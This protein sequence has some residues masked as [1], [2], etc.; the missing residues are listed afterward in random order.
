MINKKLVLLIVVWVLLLFAAAKVSSFFIVNRTSYELP[1]NLQA[2][3]RSFVLPWLNFD[4]RNFLD[5]ASKGYFQKGEH[6]LRAFF[7]LYPLL[8]YLVSKV[9]IGLVHSGLL[10]SYLAAFS[11]FYILYKL[12]EADDGKKIALKTVIL[13]LTFPT[14]FFFLAYY[15]ESLYLLCSLLV[16]WFLKKKNFGKA[17]LF[18]IFASATRVIGAVLSLAVLYEAYLYFRKKKRFP[19]ISFLSPLGLVGYSIYSFFA[20]GDPFT[21]LHGWSSWGKTFSVLGPFKSLANGLYNVARGPQPFFDSPFV[22]PVSILELVSL[23]FL[24][25]II[26]W[27]YRKIKPIYWYY[28]VINSYI[29]LAG[30][31]LQSLPRYILVL[32]PMYI[33]LAKKIKG[34]MFVIYNVVSFIILMVLCA[35]FLRGYWIS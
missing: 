30:G 13:S 11:S 12:V 6:N 20:V 23:I 16:F 26:F 18:A 19:L 3:H 14:S 32:F 24:V 1:G 22:Y 7:P 31:I 2:A 4:G 34:K 17:T 9:G 29:F 5:I 25:G 15:T 28:L 35:I 21:F 33:F 10:V 27:S 8:T